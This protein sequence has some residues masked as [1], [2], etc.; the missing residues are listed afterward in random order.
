MYASVLP[1]QTMTNRARLF[2]LRNCSMSSITCS[3]SS[4][5]FLPDLTLGPCN[6]LTYSW[7]KTA[8]WLD[9]FDLGP[10]RIQQIP[11]KDPGLDCALKAVVF[12]NVPG[13]K[14]Q[15]IQRGEWNKVVDLR[16]PAFRAFSQANCAEL[17]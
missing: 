15:V 1:H 16:D 11:I 14:H 12:I 3:A 2:R 6:L 10:H 4:I 9:F 17:G 7:L 13:A 8:P 5:L